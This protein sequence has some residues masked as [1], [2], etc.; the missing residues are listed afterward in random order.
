MAAR[1]AK[2]ADVQSQCAQRCLAHRL[3]R[4]RPAAGQYR[5]DAKEAGRRR[6]CRSVVVLSLLLSC[7][8]GLTSSGLFCAHVAFGWGPAPPAMSLPPLGVAPYT[9]GREH[10]LFDAQLAPTRSAFHTTE[11]PPPPA[12]TVPPAAPRGGSAGCSSLRWSC[13]QSATKALRFTPCQ[14][15]CTPHPP[16]PRGGSR[17]VKLGAAES[18]EQG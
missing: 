3:T 17:G 7:L 5:G 2:S 1:V 15:F 18:W 11:P 12:H 13:R 14:H 4:S 10:S 8:N 6:G 16:P 9:L